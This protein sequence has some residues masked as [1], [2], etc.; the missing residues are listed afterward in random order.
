MIKNLR[1]RMNRFDKIVVAFCAVFAALIVAFIVCLFT[2][3]LN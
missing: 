3:P 2:V 1:A